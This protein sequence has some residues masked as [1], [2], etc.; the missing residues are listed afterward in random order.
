M[1]DHFRLFS[2]ECP[3]RIGRGL[4]AACLIAVSG[5]AQAETIPDPGHGRPSSEQVL[6]ARIAWLGSI[7]SGY[8]LAYARHTEATPAPVRATLAALADETRAPIETLEQLAEVRAAE[9][10]VLLDI[11]L[12]AT[13]A[14]PPEPFAELLRFGQSDCQDLERTRNEL[15]YARRSERLPA[16]SPPLALRPE[17]R[18]APDVFYRADRITLLLVAYLEVLATGQAITPELARSYAAYTGDAP[19]PEVMEPGMATPPERLAYEAARGPAPVIA[20]ITREELIAVVQHILDTPGDWASDHYFDLFIHN[21]PCGARDL[22]TG[23]FASD[24][25]P[26]TAAEIVELA[27]TE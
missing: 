11:V 7:C 12:A 1:A 23:P 19:L 20:D 16:I 25:P 18:P 5:A 22:I 14:A 13:D 26:Q 6:T 10:A 4:L 9:F 15:D 21:T 17:L 8:S 3:T 24:Q 27:C 2:A